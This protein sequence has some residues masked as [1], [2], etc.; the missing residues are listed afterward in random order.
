MSTKLLLQLLTTTNAH[1]TYYNNVQLYH[2]LRTLENYVILR[3]RFYRSLTLYY[4]LTCLFI[5]IVV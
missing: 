3:T 4:R 2:I 1:Y 5:T